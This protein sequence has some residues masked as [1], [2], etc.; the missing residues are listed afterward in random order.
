MSRQRG[1]Q[2]EAFGC[3]LIVTVMLIDR[4]LFPLQD[5]FVLSCAV[6]SAVALII[7]IRA[8]KQA[9]EHAQKDADAAQ[10]IPVRN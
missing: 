6:V 4:F 5:N 9:D 8:V 2:F 10:D 3:I 7:G 1:L